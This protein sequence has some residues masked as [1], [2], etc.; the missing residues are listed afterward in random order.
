[1]MLFGV[2]QWDSTKVRAEQRTATGSPI[3][4]QVNETFSSVLLRKTRDKP[5]SAVVS[6]YNI[7]IKIKN[8]KEFLFLP[9]LRKT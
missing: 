4:P 7:Q 5:H 3:K 2:R 6:R 9:L 8:S 1:M